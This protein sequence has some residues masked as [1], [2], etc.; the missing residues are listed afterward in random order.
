MELVYLGI[1]SAVWITALIVVPK[2][3]KQCW[4]NEVELQMLR[5]KHTR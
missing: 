5:K 3:K 4:L 1:L 2:L